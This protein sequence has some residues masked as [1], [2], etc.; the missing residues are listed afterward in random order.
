MPLSHPFEIKRS[1][2]ARE[3]LADI[4]A[5]TIKRFGKEQ[6]PIYRERITETL[7]LIAFNPEIGVSVDDI[8]PGLLRYHM[9]QPKGRHYIYY[10][11]Q[12]GAIIIVR[13][14]HDARDQL[15]VFR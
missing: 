7:S 13:L 9:R 2:Q 3:D 10:V 6:W 5:W 14:I 8:A 15:N 11:V 4:R 12:D 1:R